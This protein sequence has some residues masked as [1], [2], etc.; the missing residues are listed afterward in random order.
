MCHGQEVSYG[1]AAP[2]QQRGKEQEQ[3]DGEV[4]EGLQVCLCLQRHRWERR[5]DEGAQREHVRG[6]MAF[7]PTCA[8]HALRQPVEVLPGQPLQGVTGEPARR[9]PPQGQERTCMVLNHSL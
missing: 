1:H 3:E 4:A 8:V 6:N 9:K 7:K 2:Q 5:E